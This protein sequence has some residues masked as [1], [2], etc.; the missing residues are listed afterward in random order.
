[1]NAGE[2]VSGPE[3]NAAISAD[4]EPMPTSAHVSGSDKRALVGER[5]AHQPGENERR[6]ERHGKAWPRRAISDRHA[7]DAT[8][9]A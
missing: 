8:S 3:K 2:T 6:R 4:A 5:E 9:P 7:G 1:M